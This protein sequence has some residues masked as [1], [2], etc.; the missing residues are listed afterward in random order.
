[1]NKKNFFRTVGKSMATM[2]FA[3]TVL[4]GFNSCVANEDNAV[5]TTPQPGGE[6]TEPYV[7]PTE[8]QLEV[9]VTADMPTAVLSQFDENS[10]GAALAKRVSKTTTA[11]D[12]DTKLVLID[13]SNIESFT[14]DDYYQMALV[15]LNGGYLALQRPTLEVA[16]G[17]ALTVQEQAEEVV[18]SVLKDMGVEMSEEAAATRRSLGNSQLVRKVNNAR[19]LTR[20]EDDDPDGV[21][22]E[23]LILVPN[24]GYL[25][26]PYNEEEMATSQAEDEDG[27]TTTV[28]HKV[29]NLLNPY[30]YGRMADGAALW[31]NTEEK[32]K[33]EALQGEPAAARASTRADGD[34]VI[35]SLMSASDAFTLAG[36]LLAFDNEGRHYSR[37]NV[38]NTTIR[39]W[40]V[41]DFGSNR[42]YYYV[43]E[44]HHIHMGGKNSDK[45]KTL[46]WGPY[47]MEDWTY[48]VGGAPSAYY[49][50]IPNYFRIEGFEN[51]GSYSHYYGS[52]LS[53]T[54]HRM[55]LSGSGN[56][57]LEQS[58]P[59]TDNNNNSQTI[60]IGT[61]DGT[62]KTSGWSFGGGGNLGGSKGGGFAGAFNFNFSYTST[63]TESHSTSFTMS[64][65]SFSKD[66]AI[67]KNAHGTEV[68]WTYEEGHTPTVISDKGW[69]EMAPD[70]LTNDIDITNKICWSVDDP[71]GSYT[72]QIYM[73][74][75]TKALFS[76]SK[77]THFSRKSYN[78]TGVDLSV[79]SRY[80]HE[81]FC[82]ITV[83][84]E[85]LT[86][87]ARNL[88]REEL[89]ETINPTMFSKKFFMPEDD[90]YGIDV[91][92]YNVAVA[93]NFLKEGSRK[94]RMIEN[95]A[96]S[97]G[98]EKFEIEWFCEDRGLE[99][100]T[101]T[102][103]IEVGK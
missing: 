27:Q 29:K 44:E 26:T 12:D 55:D 22:S 25:I 59:G 63:T 50:P 103:T 49:V 21:V 66:L 54:V 47:T 62:S 99:N 78:F 35:N 65:T 28:E 61:T 9:M 76:G 82:D 79:P 97:L 84:G 24:S 68:E 83:H 87:N 46:Y 101:F 69:H 85:D 38:T 89:M 48:T 80:R 74:D 30:H 4:T 92:K 17:F 40:N 3:A 20:G 96:E 43:E 23:L 70:I 100:V 36:D 5:D 60:A 71:S 52:W 67:T 11:I 2:L 7:E 73:E 86:K 15:F 6:V 57:K 95:A 1:M 19:A 56:I 13:G 10:V 45:N 18:N 14:E 58:M 33:A 34:Q 90:K 91:I 39:S 53:K 51:Y 37:E 77:N 32:Q 98:I 94:R 88:L 75:W 41:H 8:D 42:D 16:L 64:A 72:L 93:K 31:L 102:I 81:W